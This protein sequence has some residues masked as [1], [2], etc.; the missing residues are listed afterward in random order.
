M[1]IILETKEIS[2]QVVTKKHCFVCFCRFVTCALSL[3]S[4]N[5]DVYVFQAFFGFYQLLHY[6]LFFKGGRIKVISIYNEFRVKRARFL[7]CKCTS[8]LLGDKPGQ[9]N[10]QQFFKRFQ[11]KACVLRVN[12]TISTLKNAFNEN[13]LENEGNIEPIN[14]KKTL[15]WKFQQICDAC[16]N[17]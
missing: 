5:T 14:D 2:S 9:Q 3:R 1:K 17:R 11:T 7:L 15:L 13:H 6:F 4:G 10:Y 16:F 12:E 8:F